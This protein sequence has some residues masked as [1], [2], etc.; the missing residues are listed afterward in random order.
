MNLID[1]LIII[2]LLFGLWKG[3]RKGLLNSLVGLCSTL[4]GLFVAWQTHACVAGWLDN[5]FQL[6]TKL[7]RYFEQRLVLSETVS[8]LNVGTLSL[9]ATNTSGATL[10]L[11]ARLKLQLV[12]FAEKMGEQIGLG[13][14]VYL[15]DILYLFLAKLVLQ[16]LVIILIWFL[17]DK[18]LL[19]IAQLITKLTE[20]TFLG[21][22]NKIGGVCIGLLSRV[23]VLTIII[24]LSSPFFNL[25]QY[26]EPSFL[27][28]VLQ[29]TSEAFLVPWFTSAFSFLTGKLFSFWL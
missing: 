22:L 24:G 18:G 21:S 14:D 3:F 11:S 19:L 12:E 28:S 26:T 6:T 1:L 9:P 7:A 25:A 10:Q 20:N 15:G 27:S 4:L 23:F 17:V 8:Q 5:G 16:I 29:T 2:F 13:A